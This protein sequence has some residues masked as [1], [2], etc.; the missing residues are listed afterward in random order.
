MKNLKLLCNAAI[1][2]IFI[3]LISSCSKDVL[4][5]EQNASQNNRLVTN[6]PNSV[7]NDPGSIQAIIDPGYL[8]VSMEVFNDDYTSKTTYTNEDGFIETREI[9]PGFYTVVFHVVTDEPLPRDYLDIVIEKVE[10]LTGDVTDLRII[11][12]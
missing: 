7:S 2:S 3:F 11:K 6:V 9:P 12:F 1:F 8:K 4:N 10:V 5:N